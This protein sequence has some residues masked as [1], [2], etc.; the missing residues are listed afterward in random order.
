MR[1]RKAGSAKLAARALD[2]EVSS[3]G[4]ISAP[5]RVVEQM[6]IDLIKPHPRNAKTHPRKQ[7]RQIA[8]SIVQFGFNTP[9][10]VTRDGHLIAGH[11]RYE[12]A[13]L[14]GLKNLPVVILTGL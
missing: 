11:G 5:Q 12:A 10:A 9:L 14:L 6:A 8:D 13:K 1:K 2:T 4:C 3:N 7:I